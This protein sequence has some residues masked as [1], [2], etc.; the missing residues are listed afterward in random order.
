MT[1]KGSATAA[2]VLIGTGHADVIIGGSAN[3]TI[4][5]GQGG[6]VLTGGG[7]NDKF[8]FL[9]GDSSIGTGTFDTITDFV[10]NTKANA[11]GTG[12]DPTPG[13][14]NGDVLGFVASTA[15]QGHGIK[16]FVANN[17]A[18]ATTFLANTASAFADQASAALDSTTS[19]LYVDI[20]GDGV[21]DF[22]IDLVG[23]TSISEAAFNIHN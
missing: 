1:I 17:A 8:E 9:T 6:D 15:I 11:G 3:D 2:N 13:S 7:G 22:Y 16:V 12:A 14:A 21:A 19:K 20:S 10:A 23:V 18:D 4:T 5:G